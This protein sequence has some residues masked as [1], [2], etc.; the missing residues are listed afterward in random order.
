MKVAVPL[1]KT[2]EGYLLSYHFG[3][4]AY[5]AFAEVSDGKYEVIDIIENEAA[6]GGHG[7]GH[8]LIDLIASRGVDAVVVHEIGQGARGELAARGIKIYQAPGIAPL[9]QVLDMLAKG[10]L[11]ALGS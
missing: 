9:E 7:A 4:A 6:R 8:R 2:S 5:V 3:R 1:I 11:G 10:E